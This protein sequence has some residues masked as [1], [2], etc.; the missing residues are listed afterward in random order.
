M[1]WLSKEWHCW[2][3]PSDSVICGSVFLPSESC[4]FNQTL[5]KSGTTFHLLYKTELWFPKYCL[6]ILPI[7]AY[8]LI[9]KDRYFS[10]HC[11][12][13]WQVILFLIRICC[14][15]FHSCDNDI[16][17]MPS[18]WWSLIENDTKFWGWWKRLQ[19]NKGKMSKK[20]F[21][22]PRTWGVGLKKGMVLPKRIQEKP[23]FDYR[24][25]TKKVSHGKTVKQ[26]WRSKQYSVYQTCQGGHCEL[27]Q[28]VEAP[29][30]WTTK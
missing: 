28:N 10:H 21:H 2:F 13:I 19:P 24:M 30:C 17:S 14:R 15:A 23:C 4:Y 9:K 22:R 16:Y 18:L 8:L 25:R 29:R 6:D 12:V 27:V 3:F 26:G 20:P 1:Y 7:I 5:S 11:V